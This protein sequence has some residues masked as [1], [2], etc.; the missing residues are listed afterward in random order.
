M[1]LKNSFTGVWL[2]TEPSLYEYNARMDKAEA[3]P[4]PVKANFYD[5]EE[6]GGG[7][8]GLPY[9]LEVVGPIGVIHING[10]LTNV[11]R[12][13]NA[14][15]KIPSYNA[16]KD[17]LVYAARD[18]D[19]QHILLNINSGG[20]PVAGLSDTGEMIKMIDQNIKP[21][22][23]YSESA[24]MS[25]AYWLGS[26]ATQQYASQTAMVGS[27]GV[28]LTHMEYSKE[29]AEMGITATV[30]RAGE[31]KALAGPYE[32]LSDKAKTILQ[33]ELNYF[34]QIFIENIAANLNVSASVVR[35]QMGEGRVFIGA[36][37]VQAGLV[38]A[39]TT[40]D[41][42]LTSLEAISVD[43]SPTLR[44]TAKKSPTGV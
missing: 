24:M 43:T 29:M 9:L 36:Q 40:L 10:A 30:L 28:I 7:S 12:W 31:F 2:G 5:D 22:Y 6:S 23:A 14:Y 44:Q 25:A 19:I 1:Q 21:V 18:A 41:K 20:G 13:Y 35:T 15:F 4:A 11:D 8:D 3:L 17:A 33:T 37:A 27:I 32:P 42:L 38:S 39:V 16:I 34:E 26:A